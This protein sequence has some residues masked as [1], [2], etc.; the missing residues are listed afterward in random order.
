MT[1]TNTELQAHLSFLLK[2]A[3]LHKWDR[4]NEQNYTANDQNF[5]K[6]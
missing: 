2:E 6:L 5:D 4:W 3:Q 1:E